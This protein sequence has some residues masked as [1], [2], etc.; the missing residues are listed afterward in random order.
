MRL[1]IDGYEDLLILLL[2]LVY[3]V[4]AVLCF[5]RWPPMGLGALVLC[6]LLVAFEFET[7]TQSGLNVAFLLAPVLIGVWL[8]ARMSRPDD[9]H[10][11]FTRPVLPLGLFLLVA[12][13]SFLVGQFPWFSTSGAPLSA[14]LAGLAVF[15]FS[16]GIFLVAAHQLQDLRWLQRITWLFL[17]LGALHILARLMAG[18]YPSSGTLIPAGATGSLF[19]T[20]FIA[21]GLGQVVFNRGLNPVWRVII[22]GLVAAALWIGLFEARSWL[23]GWLPGF[24]SAMVILAVRT[25]IL[26][27]FGVVAGS[28]LVSFNLEKTI[29]L[30]MTADQQYSLMTRLEALKVMSQIIKVNPLLGLGPANYY[31]YT[32]LYPILGWHVKFNSHNNYVDIIAQTGF[33]GLAC[34]IWFVVEVCRVV[35]KLRGQLSSGFARG[36]A[37]GALGG[38]VGTLTAAMLGDWMIPFIYNVGLRGFRASVLAWLF[39]GGLVALEQTMHRP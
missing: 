35:W 5:L 9:I 34:F 6:S 38:L 3:V 36:Y 25:P 19:W 24:V 27:I 17:A 15:L 18:V 14:Q 4:G 31:H 1:S 39:L 23:S 22:A 29:A 37:Y 20:W 32:P 16:G 12:A 11:V 26:T 33:L 21:L 30:L 10:L 13:L 8:L 7:G 28:A 2:T